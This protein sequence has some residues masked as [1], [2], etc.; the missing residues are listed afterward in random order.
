MLDPGWL[1]GPTISGCF[2][3]PIHDHRLLPWYR[4]SHTTC[5]F[6]RLDYFNRKSRC[7]L[8]NHFAP[9]H[10]ARLSPTRG[11]RHTHLATS[12]QVSLRTPDRSGG[13]L[14]GLVQPKIW[15]MATRGNLYGSLSLKPCE[16]AILN[17]KNVILKI[18]CRRN[19]IKRW[20]KSQVVA[21]IESFLKRF[22]QD[23]YIKFTD[24]TADSSQ[25]TSQKGYFV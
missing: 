23:N 5:R 17:H 14:P 18:I 10:M 12:R 7:R 19:W 9:V 13:R 1:E 25:I 22:R 2:Q 24:H 16:N 4:P 3:L 20:R 21:A 11:V 8:S 15:Q 6:A